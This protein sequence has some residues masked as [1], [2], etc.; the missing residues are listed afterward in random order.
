M[1]SL[2]PIDHSLEVSDTDEAEDTRQSQLQSLKVFYTPRSASVRLKGLG[3]ILPGVAHLKLVAVGLVAFAAWKWGPR[4]LE[5][6]EADRRALP[7][8]ELVASFAPGFS[9]DSEASLIE[10]RQELGGRVQL[11]YTYESALPEHPRVKAL[12]WFDADEEAARE[13][14][15]KTYLNTVFDWGIGREEPVG[16]IWID[17]HRPLGDVRHGI[18]SRLYHVE[19]GRR[20]LGHVIALRAG[21]RTLYSKLEGNLLSDGALWGLALELLGELRRH[22][23]A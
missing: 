20:R 8:A 10:K 12:I 13:T 14:F 6:N 15:K 17:E 21:T 9:V 5:A 19:L 16:L 23:G 18:E 22:P 1:Q 3:W 11:K 4:P 7:T 2:A